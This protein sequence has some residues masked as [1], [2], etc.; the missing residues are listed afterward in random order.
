MADVKVLK[1]AKSA[2]RKIL[3]PDWISARNALAP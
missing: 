3:Y 2:L 1:T